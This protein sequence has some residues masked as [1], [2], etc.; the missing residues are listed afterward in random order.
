MRCD[1]AIIPE[2]ALEMIFRRG[3]RKSPCN[4]NQRDLY[5]RNRPHSRPL[6]S[7]TV[8][9]DAGCGTTDYPK[10]LV[11]LMSFDTQADSENR[12]RRKPRTALS[13]IHSDGSGTS[14]FMVV[15]AATTDDTFW[16]GQ[17]LPET[18]DL[19]LAGVSM[20]Q[21]PI[22]QHIVAARPE[23]QV[24]FFG[25]KFRRSK[26]VLQGQAA[27]GISG[28]LRPFDCLT[29]NHCAPP[30]LDPSRERSQ[31][32]R[33]ALLS[34]FSLRASDSPPDSWFPGLWRPRQSRESRYSATGSFAT[35][36]R[37]REPER[38]ASGLGG[39]L[40]SRVNRIRVRCLAVACGAQVLDLERGGRLRVAIARQTHQ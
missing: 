35:R 15:S 4:I 36:T 40:D 18:I 25:A 19:L 2:T 5:L 29:R 13:Q 34:K 37:P 11:V 1:T 33:R 38:Y 24:M 20:S 3:S 7:A 10:N 6:I 14:R 32:R 26:C 28:A 8:C 17:D 16:I 12:L 21:S 31:I 9:T 22:Y 27:L 30:T 23:L 39:G